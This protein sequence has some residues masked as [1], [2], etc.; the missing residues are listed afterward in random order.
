MIIE[1]LL[2]LIGIIIG[3]KLGIF[4]MK[5]SLLKVLKNYKFEKIEEKKQ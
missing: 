5:L 4:G 2:T 1:I 3:V